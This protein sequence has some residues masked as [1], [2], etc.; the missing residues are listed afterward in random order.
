M[1]SD[2]LTLNKKDE[3]GDPLENVEFTL[4][5][6]ENDSRGLPASSGVTDANGTLTLKGL[7]PGQTYELVETFPSGFQEHYEWSETLPSE[8]TKTKAGTLLVSV[9]QGNDPPKFELTLENI[10]L[11]YTISIPVVDHSG[12]VVPGSE[13]ILYEDPECT[14][15]VKDIETAVTGPDGRVVLEN[16][17]YRSEPYYFK[18]VNAPDGYTFSD[19][20]YTFSIESDGTA[21]EIT[22]A[23]TGEAVDKIINVYTKEE[24]NNPSSGTSGTSP[25]KGTENQAQDNRQ[26]NGQD[27]AQKTNVPQ[28]GDTS[29]LFPNFCLMLLSLVAG[30]ICLRLKRTR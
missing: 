13:F 16:V 10:L 8:I 12:N 9:P 19:T 4:Y 29:P 22:D 7:K 14:I 27:D 5:L 15:P 1:A 17:P 11:R 24:Q 23:E 26:N 6:W 30:L 18:Q 2:F 3:D 28:T 25:T 21:S 20:V